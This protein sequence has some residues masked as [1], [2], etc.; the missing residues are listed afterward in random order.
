MDLAPG[1]AAPEHRHELD[2]LFVYTGP[3]RIKLVQPGRPDLV[4]E[5]DDLFARFVRVD[6]PLTHHIENAADEPHRQILV[7]L[8]RTGERGTS[9]T[10]G[11]SRVL[12]GGTDT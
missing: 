4:E 5:F 2:Y 1:Q 8:K 3:S 12:D 7:E 9:A 10:N 6:G 11:R